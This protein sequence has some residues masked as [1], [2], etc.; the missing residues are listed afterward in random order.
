MYRQYTH[1]FCF[2]LLNPFLPQLCTNV[3]LSAVL[4]LKNSSKNTIIIITKSTY[5]VFFI[6]TSLIKYRRLTQDLRL[7]FWKNETILPKK[8]KENNNYNTRKC[9]YFLAAMFMG[10]RVKNKIGVWVKK[11]GRGKDGGQHNDD[12]NCRSDTLF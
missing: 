1:R 8:T 10:V 6:T 3:F 5:L 2:K 12:Y 11:R 7:G 9:F 4:R